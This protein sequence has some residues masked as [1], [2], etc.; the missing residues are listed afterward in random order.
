M[1]L[2]TE[3]SRRWRAITFVLA[4]VLVASYI[5]HAND[6]TYTH[7]G[8]S[9]GLAYGYLAAG[10]I[11]LL[12]LFS[13]RKRAHRSRLG[14]LENWAQSHSYLGLLVVIVVLAHSG[15]RFQDRL[16][17]AALL[18]MIA[19]SVT[20]VVGAVLYTLVPRILTTIGTEP[21]VPEIAEQL[22]QLHRSMS[23][24]GR[25]ASQELHA[26]YL[27]TTQQ[28]RPIR[29]AGW[30]ILSRMKTS[31]GED[32]KLRALLRQVDGSEQVA[33]QRMLVLARQHGELRRLL[34][35]QQRYRN[36][37]QV[38]LYL[39]VPLTAA[40]VALVVAHALSAYYFTGL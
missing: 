33:L 24:I 39:H 37:L 12:V 3:A 25:D 20:G 8:S 15:F 38:W 13:V 1:F 26:V 17:V 34:V 7:G 6:S 14:T 5:W 19:V 30:R 2:R 35:A 21:A 28:I 27:H 9:W 11:F 31:Q 4:L 32:A 10:L 36:L 18:V 23:R 29:L 40:L 16:A 22:N